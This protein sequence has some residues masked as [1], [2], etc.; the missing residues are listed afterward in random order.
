MKRKRRRR[1]Q[2]DIGDVF[3]VPQQDGLWSVGQVIGLMDPPYGAICAFY[4]ILCEPDCQDVATPLP[5]DKLISSLSV[6]K[7]ALKWGEW[8]VIK[9]QQ[10]VTLDRKHWANEPFRERRWVGAIIHNT[11][12]VEAFL[13]AFYALEAWDDYHNPNYLD[14]LLISPDKK[15]KNL[16]LKKQ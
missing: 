14:S 8:K 13:N 1:Q 12:V 15:P 4:D 2:W 10:P 5:F 11:V 6:T 7:E 16:I 9:K 3:I